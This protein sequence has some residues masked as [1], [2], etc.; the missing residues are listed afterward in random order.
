MIGELNHA[1]IQ[2]L[3]TR[4]HLGHL[5]VFGDGR[6]FVFPVSYGYD[7]D[8]IYV[9]S[10]EGLKVR[11]MRSHPEVCFEIEEIEGPGRWRTAI[12]HGMFEEVTSEA[13]RDRAFAVIAGQGGIRAP[14]S[15]APYLGGPEAIV[16]YRIRV[17]EMSGRFERDEPL[18]LDHTPHP[19]A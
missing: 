10:H 11:L 18:V 14:D 9:Q 2:A 4:L 1:S 12:F 6:V 15:I 8:C 13:E 7:G 17:V 19:T 16:V 5:G 3:L